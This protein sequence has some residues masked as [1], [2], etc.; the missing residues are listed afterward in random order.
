M[1]SEKKVKRT[2]NEKKMG[3]DG[4]REEGESEEREK[5]GKGQEKGGGRGR[6]IRKE[7]EQTGE[8]RRMRCHWTESETDKR[9]KCR[10]GYQNLR[11]PSSPDSA[12]CRLRVNWR[13]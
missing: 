10:N 8:G 11:S 5:K 4:R 6:E 7:G 1:K 2:K 9:G 12:L 3:K 13:R